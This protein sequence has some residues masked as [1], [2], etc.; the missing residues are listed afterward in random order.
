[1]YIILFLFWVSTCVGG[2][3]LVSKYSVHTYLRGI[4]I[5]RRMCDIT[6]IDA[7]VEHRVAKN[8]MLFFSNGD[9]SHGR[10]LL[11]CTLPYHEGWRILYVNKYTY[12]PRYL[13]WKMQTAQRNELVPWLDQ[14]GAIYLCCLLKI[15][16]L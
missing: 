10:Y 2:V 1:M 9:Y 6:R 13:L 5:S 4:M 14:L 3:S 12:I 7:W 15:S 11:V 16:M 8:T